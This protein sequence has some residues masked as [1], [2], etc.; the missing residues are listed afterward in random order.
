MPGEEAEK[1]KQWSEQLK[2][3]S[4]EDQLQALRQISSHDQ[5]AGLAVPVVGL[6]GSSNDEVRMWAAEALE[7]SVRPE[8]SEVLMLIQQLDAGPD[9]EICYWA[10]TMLGRLGTEAAMA[11]DALDRCLRESMYLPARERATWALS[12][13]GFRARVAV[14]SLRE[15]AESAPPRLRQLAGEALRA[16]SD[17]SEP[18]QQD[19]ESGEAA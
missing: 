15:A 19:R 11:A 10:A 1:N 14:P 6:S 8:A 3:D 17:L 9:G 18:S 16:I 12:Q 5:V 13:I 4:V 2:S 7:S